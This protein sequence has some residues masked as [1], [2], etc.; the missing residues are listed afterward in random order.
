MA[1]LQYPGDHES[2][3][4]H[5]RVTEKAK[6]F[7]LTIK[8]EFVFKEAKAVKAQAG[9]SVYI[10]AS[11]SEQLTKR[12]MSS[13]HTVTQILEAPNKTGAVLKVF[14]FANIFNN[15][16]KTVINGSIVYSLEYELKVDDPE[17]QIQQL[18]VC[19]GTAHRTRPLT[20]D[21]VLALEARAL[22][23]QNLLLYTD[24]SHK[25]IWAGEAAQ[26]LSGRWYKAGARLSPAT[27]LYSA[28]VP[29][30]IVSAPGV[31]S[32]ALS[33]RPLLNNL[34]SRFGRLGNANKISDSI[35]NN[36][37]GKRTH[38][39][40]PL[41][42]TKTNA[43]TLGLAYGFNKTNFFLENGL[44][45]GLIRNKNI[46][47]QCFTIES[48]KIL[49]KRVTSNSPDNRLTNTF[50]SQDFKAGSSDPGEQ[51]VTSSPTQLGLGLPQTDIV[52][53]GA[54]D[55]S[56]GEKTYGIYAYGVEIVVIDHTRDLLNASIQALQDDALLLQG[57]ADLASMPS[58]YSRN[59]GEITAEFLSS[60]AGP[61]VDLANRPDYRATM[62][63]LSVLNALYEDPAAQL[64]GSYENLAADL[65][66]EVNVIT[67]GPQGLRVLLRL[68]ENLALELKMFVGDNINPKSFKGNSFVINNSM[69]G[70]ERRL[71][72]IKHYFNNFVNEEHFADGGYDYLSATAENGAMTKYAPLNVVPYETMKNIL[73]NEKLKVGTTATPPNQPAAVTGNPTVGAAN[74]LRA[75]FLP[76]N[77]VFLTPNYIKLHGKYMK[78][79]SAGPN[80]KEINNLVATSLL[81]ANRGRTNQN[82]AP[83][84]DTIKV[85]NSKV[86]VPATAMLTLKNNLAVMEQL[87]CTLEIERD[88]VAAETNG[89]FYYLSA[90]RGLDTD[91]FVDAAIKLSEPSPFVINNKTRVT[92]HSL[93]SFVLSQTNNS[94]NEGYYRDIKDLNNG[95][96]AYLT[97]TDYFTPSPTKNFSMSNST[98]KNITDKK[99]FK[100]VNMDVDVAKQKILDNSKIKKT[101]N[102]KGPALLLAPRD[103]ELALAS[104]QEKMYI[105]ELGGI[106]NGTDIVQ[107]ALKYGNIKKIKCLVGWR[108]RASGFSSNDGNTQSGLGASMWTPLWKDLTE[109]MINS[110]AT[111]GKAMLCR[112]VDTLTEFSDYTGVRAPVYNDLFI[113]GNSQPIGSVTQ[114]AQPTLIRL[115]PAQFTKL[116]KIALTDTRRLKYSRAVIKGVKE[117]LVEQLV[118]DASDIDSGSGRGALSVATGMSTNGND[119]VLPTGER[120]KGLFHLYRQENGEVVAMAGRQHSDKAHAVLTP[121][122]NKAHRMM[123]SS[124][125]PAPTGD[126]IYGGGFTNGGGY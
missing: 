1:A 73:E 87:G 118:P 9:R 71:L 5:V 80:Q 78:I 72:T 66:S 74:P 69:Y 24:K 116:N 104:P 65:F 94:L 39:F 92:P 42:V 85:V 67:G 4:V 36:F 86:E 48:V 88:D 37:K 82:V 16:E 10:I 100:S 34:S 33:C 113:L 8:L 15:L 90:P 28:L 57:F 59:T 43:N 115:S 58:N 112:M 121:V 27:R 46:L 123:H 111:S 44:F 109:K 117:N 6:Q 17:K 55:G 50:I 102:M 105:S 14:D 93:G 126:A 25:S 95:V 77:P 29:N 23:K 22:P 41:Y 75:A 91:E 26:D 12:I 120:Y 84:Y 61:S 21:K 35:G 108:T 106:L 114:R 64:G 3:I 119:F 47:N 52:M 76:S 81:A 38:Y 63:Y 13:G 97:Q 30:T 98:V 122:S 124:P 7:L 125:T 40:T 99:V 49:R 20:M 96:L 103:Q 83:D 101:T 107:F 62:T 54:L 60:V 110:Y 70:K 53:M 32:Q 89:A 51:T 11:S 19:A 56:I 79:N 2:N 68:I 31:G 45:S 18:L